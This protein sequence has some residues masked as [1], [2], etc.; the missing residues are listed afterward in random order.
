MWPYS[1][2]FCVFPE[3]L[4]YLSF[5]VELT[6]DLC[7]QISN[8]SDDK[9]QKMQICDLCTGDDPNSYKCICF[10]TNELPNEMIENFLDLGIYRNVHNQLF[11]KFWKQNAI[12][13]ANAEITFT[14]VFNEI[15]TPTIKQCHSLVCNLYSKTIKL[16]EIIQLSKMENFPHQLSALSS[17]LLHDYPAMMGGVTP[18]DQWVPQLMAHIVLYQDISSSTKCIDAANV[19]LKMQ[20]SLHLTGDFKLVESLT[21]IVSIVTDMLSI[22][23]HICY[24]FYHFDFYNS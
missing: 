15:W 24:V 14:N 3:M 23:V 2:L 4:L 6:Q 5:N 12:V 9:L 17:A 20:K 1:T 16:S 18:P 8:H 7:K 22:Y 19:L 13:S 11:E 21:R 10:T